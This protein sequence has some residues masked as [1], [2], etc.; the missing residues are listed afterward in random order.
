MCWLYL[1]FYLVCLENAGQ[2]TRDMEKDRR[3]VSTKE[4]C[5]EI[6]RGLLDYSK[7]FGLFQSHELTID[8]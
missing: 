3:T 4:K 7:Q 6:A 2:G 1:V 8:N 5:E